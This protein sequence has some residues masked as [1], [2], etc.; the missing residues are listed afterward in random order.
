MVRTGSSLIG[1]MVCWIPICWAMWAVASVSDIPLPSICERTVCSAR[2]LSPRRNQSSPPNEP[3][4]SIKFQVSPAR[5]QPVSVLFCCAKAYVRL[6]M[7]GL[8]CKPRCS[9]SSP[10][11][12][13]N[14]S[15]S[16]DR[17]CARPSAN[18]APPT[19]P[20]KA[21]ILVISEINLLQGGG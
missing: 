21:R 11:F 2:S 1:A 7:S 13:A 15:C 4:V 6:S 19:P 12:T 16:G 8:M 3:S 9:K 14:S 18:L 10:V 17:I 20:V 5:P